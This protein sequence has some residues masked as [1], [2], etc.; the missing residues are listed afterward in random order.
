MT[1]TRDLRQD[2]AAFEN[3]TLEPMA[4]L[5]MFQ[6]LID[7]GVVWKMPGDYPRN[8]AMMIALGLCEAP[9]DS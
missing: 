7:T 3:G 4:V 9:P 5:G 1:G 8:A 2:V 6:F